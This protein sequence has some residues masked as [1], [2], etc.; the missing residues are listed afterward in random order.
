MKKRLLAVVLAFCMIASACMLFA[1]AEKA[2]FTKG[3]YYFNNNIANPTYA[4]L[5]KNATLSSTSIPSR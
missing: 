3:T 5:D 4:D 2:T 1:S